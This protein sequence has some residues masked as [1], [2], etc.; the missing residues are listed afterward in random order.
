M[1]VLS[2]YIIYKKFKVTILYYLKLTSFN[3]KTSVMIK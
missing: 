1:L 3:A 2:Y